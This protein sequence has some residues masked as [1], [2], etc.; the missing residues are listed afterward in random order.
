M[1]RA[2]VKLNHSKSICNPR[3]MAS[4][5]VLQKTRGRSQS[6]SNCSIIKLFEGGNGFHYIQYVCELSFY[7]L[8]RSCFHHLQSSICSRKRQAVLVTWR[9]AF[10][11]TTAAPA[12][13]RR[14]DGEGPIQNSLS[15]SSSL[16][17]D[18][19]FSAIS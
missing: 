15:P 16:L 5:Y 12:T 9:C 6:G 11:I 14:W 13:T 18:K 7:V 8:R 3:K 19:P 1:L 2:L 10:G 4:K 17:V